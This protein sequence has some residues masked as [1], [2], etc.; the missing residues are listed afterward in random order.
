MR[1]G[2]YTVSYAEN[3]VLVAESREVVFHIV[4]EFGR[5]CDRTNLMINV[6]KNKVL[7]VRKVQIADIE[8]VRVN[9]EGVEKAVKF[10]CSGGISADWGMEEVDS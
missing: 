9:W 3:V 8:K 6:D 5:E 2:D 10:K 4:D 7:V 1:V